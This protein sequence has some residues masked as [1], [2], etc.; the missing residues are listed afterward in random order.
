M[1]NYSKGANGTISG[2]FGSVVG[3]SWRGIDYLRGLPKKSK[4]PI[5]D[6]Q[7]AVRAKFALSA[8]QL[9][10]IKDVLYIGFGDKKLSTITGYNAAVRV[11]ISTCILGEYPDY[12]VAYPKMQLSKGG[13]VTP[14]LKHVSLEVDGGG[15]LTLNWTYVPKRNAFAD[16]TVM[17][18]VYNTTSKLYEV[19]DSATRAED[20][21]TIDM[22]A[23]AGNVLHIW[24]FCITR[25][26]LKVSATQY[27]GS[28]TLP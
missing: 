3:S 19:N 9:S 25:D 17:A 28:V 26:G 24:I 14:Q 1:G 6:L 15:M 20:T 23:D 8:A 18:V 13:G 7:L 16:D 27:V 5:S 12:T 10:P 4:K 21:L 22:D 2:K 11:F